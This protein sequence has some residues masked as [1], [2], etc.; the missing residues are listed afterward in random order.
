MS[1][2][3]AFVDANRARACAL[4]VIRGIEASEASAARR[5]EATARHMRAPA[6]ERRL[7][8]TNALLARLFAGGDAKGSWTSEDAREAHRENEAAL[9]RR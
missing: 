2:G 7:R 5:A 9:G 4:T 1:D 3:L 8:E 6:V